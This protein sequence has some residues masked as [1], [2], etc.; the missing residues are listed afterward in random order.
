MKL[1]AGR[2]VYGLGAIAFGTITLIWHQA[3]LI[4][5]IPDKVILVYTLGIL[6]LI[7]GL[8]IQWQRTMR[9]GA[10]IIAAIFLIFSFYW[11]PPI[12]KTPL[13]Y[14]NWGNFFEIFSIALGGIF[15]FASDNRN[16]PLGAAKAGKVAYWCFGICAIS[17]SLYQLF[18]LTYTAG[19]VPKWIPPGQMFWAVTT[20]IAFALAAI[21]ILSRRSAL[22]AS[23][24]LVVMFIG[25]GLLI[26]T[27]ACFNDPHNLVNW[28][29]NT[30]NLAVAGS[31]WIIADFISVPNI[32]N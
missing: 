14:S 16:Y 10:I 27:P 5:D 20:S 12:I 3:D 21:A 26:W 19:L 6:E 18:Y 17:Y 31:V 23:R 8:A 13:V 7:G 28:V 29:S 32:K 2:H 4:S 11:I 25:F 15:V 24:L 1:R 22:L 30:E 9:F